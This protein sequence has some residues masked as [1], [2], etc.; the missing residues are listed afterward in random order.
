MSDFGR[1]Y[2]EEAATYAEMLPDSLAAR[3]LDRATPWRTWRHRRRR[4]TPR[5]SHSRT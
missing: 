3:P 4:W 5:S 2:G 1:I